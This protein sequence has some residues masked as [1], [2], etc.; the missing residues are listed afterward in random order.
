MQSR[1]KEL[2]YREKR[3][4]KGNPNGKDKNGK[5]VINRRERMQWNDKL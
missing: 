5:G 3:K 2:E 4:W 1:G